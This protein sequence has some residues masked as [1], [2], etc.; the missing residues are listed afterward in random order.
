MKKTLLLVIIAAVSTFIL[1]SCG[2]EE[3]IL[4]NPNGS[5]PNANPNNPTSKC[6]ITDIK[7]IEDN[8]VYTTKFTYNSKNQLETKEE[9]GNTTKYEYDKDNRITKMIM[10]GDG[11]EIFTYEYDGKGNMSKVKY[12]S[13]GTQVTISL[14]EYIFTTNAKG[15]V[16]KVQAISEDGP[17]DF[18]FEYD[19]KN[20]IK[21]IIA[22]DGSDKFTLLENLKLDDKSNVYLNTN[23]S[24]A[25]LPHIIIGTIFGVNMTSFF[26]ANNILSD[27]VVS[28]FSGDAETSTYT[29]GYTT[30]GFPSKMSVVRV[31]DGETT[32]AEETYTYTCK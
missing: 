20:N 18:L 9:D 11:V 8:E 23:L 27:N 13:E 14:S 15:Q 17:T 6:Y 24:K 22:T 2:K 4:A 3:G 1:I 21:K 31:Y 10:N 7:Y 5:D 19:T 12:T 28:I 29:Y 30:E 26:N 16:E 25:Y 32:K